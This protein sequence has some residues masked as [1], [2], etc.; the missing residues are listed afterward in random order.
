ML[1]FHELLPTGLC[2]LSGFAAITLQHEGTSYN[3]G[4]GSDF[5]YANVSPVKKFIDKTSAT[6][7]VYSLYSFG[8]GISL[9]YTALYSLENVK[10]LS[11]VNFRFHSG[12][13]F[14]ILNFMKVYTD[15]HVSSGLQNHSS[16][17]E[18]KNCFK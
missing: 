9:V 8:I 17:R 6:R 5:V 3:Y 4:S 11:S 14:F 7:Y 12:S 16:H 10:F 2:L 1:S 15:I 13:H 18:S